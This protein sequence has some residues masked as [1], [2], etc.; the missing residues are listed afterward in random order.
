MSSYEKE[1]DV[2]VE[3]AQRAARLIRMYAGELEEK[4]VNSK[5]VHDLVTHA[6]EEAQRL[7]VA[8]LE[9]AFP[10][11]HILA[12][13]GALNETA[14]VSVADGH[15]WVIDPIDGT[16]NFTHGV[17][18]YA[19]SIA[20]QHR[21]ELVVGVILDASRGELFTAVKGQGAYLNGARIEVSKTA[22]LDDSLVST[23]FPYRSFSHVDTYLGVLRQFMKKTRGVRRPGAASI[24]LA[25]VACGRFDGFF[26][27]GLSPWDVAAGTVIVREA[28]GRV[29]DFK[30]QPEVLVKRQI[31]ATNGGLHDVCLELVHPLHEVNGQPGSA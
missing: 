10:E 4:H 28:G 16:T 7:V 12:E 11:H 18:P 21:D 29:T 30:A 22:V 23:G 8:T 20:L 3:A 19:V 1:R 26:E 15:R 13:E 5:G 25:Y 27:T 9:E 6:D 31:L 2:A 24:D 14:G 17:P